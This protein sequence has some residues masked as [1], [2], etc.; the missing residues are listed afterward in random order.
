MNIKLAGTRAFGTGKLWAISNGPTIMVAGGVLGFGIT[1]ALAIRQTAKAVDV[2][3]EIKKDID[4]NRLFAKK[5]L[6]E[7]SATE[8]AAQRK[9]LIKVYV[10]SSLKLG[11][12]YWPV[13]AAGTVSAGL[14]LQGHNIL[15]KRNATL[16]AAYT[17]LDTSYRLYRSRV[18]DEIGE[19]RE[20]EL[21]TGLKKKVL[22]A[23]PE[24]GRLEPCE[25]FDPSDF[26][27]E[28]S[29]YARCFDDTSTS[30]SRTPEYNLTFLLTQQ[31]FANDRLQMVGY[32]F[33]NEVY[34]A[35]GLPRTQAG[36]MVG[37]KVGHP[38]SD[39]YVSF[40]IHRLDSDARAFVNGQEEVIWLDFNVD[41]IITI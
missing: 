34:E 41:G 31:Q 32:L 10:R 29:Q 27:P 38:N 36:Q 1:T 19:E 24:N 28:F 3:P 5:E 20:Q 39:G 14:V 9:A 33:L 8:K 23:D 17:A 15:V 12:I 18:S 21:Y 7:A 26:H 25:A 11:R 22:P 4:E 16:V 13:F 6:E 40:N 30:F 2:L 35:L 37:W